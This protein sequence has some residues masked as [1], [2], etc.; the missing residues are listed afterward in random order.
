MDSRVPDQRV[1]GSRLEFLYTF[2][3]VFLYMLFC[4]LVGCTLV[5]I[6]YLLSKIHVSIVFIYAFFVVTLLFAL[7]VY[8]GGI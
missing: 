1:G 7:N 2:G 5:G 3:A 4:L 8:L 6:G